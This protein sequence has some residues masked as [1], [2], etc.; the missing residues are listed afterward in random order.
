MQKKYT[1]N[2]VHSFRRLVVRK[3]HPPYLVSK[4][5]SMEQ[6]LQ[7][8][9]Q[10]AKA[11]YECHLFSMFAS[12][13]SKL[14]KYLRNCHASNLY[15]SVL[16]WNNIHEN[17]PAGKCELFNRYFNTVFTAN[18]SSCS[19]TDLN[20]LPFPDAQLSSLCFSESDVW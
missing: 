14:Y 4:L 10:Q 5:R 20:R 6:T 15:P 16:S 2:K 18:L 3:S 7:L 11:S 8:E 12:D 17:Q 13:K 19:L 9:I 1:K